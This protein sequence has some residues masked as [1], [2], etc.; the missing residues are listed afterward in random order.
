[1]C[2]VRSPSTSLRAGSRP[3]GKNAGLRDDAWNHQLLLASLKRLPGTNLFNV[4]CYQ[5]DGHVD[6]DLWFLKN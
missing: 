4:H 6:L 2:Q 1:M 5:Y 3:A